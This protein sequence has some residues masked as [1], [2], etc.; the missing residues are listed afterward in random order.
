MWMLMSD[1][2][3]EFW[4]EKIFEAIAQSVG[5]FIFFDEQLLRWGNKQLA[6]VLVEFEL[7][8]GL[9]DVIDLHIKDTHLR[10]PVDFWKEPFRCHSCWQPGHIKTNFPDLMEHNIDPAQLEVTED[11]AGTFGLEVF[12][13]ISFLGKMQLFFP[14]FFNKLS[15]DEIDYLKINESWVL[16]IFGDFW[17]LLM[18]KFEEPGVRSGLGTKG[19]GPVNS[20]GCS[21]RDT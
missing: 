7:D 21:P 16:E 5:K 18:K 6:W 13:K 3:I 11:Q 17:D 20:L 19:V 14:S 15:S 8:R 12:D 4:L 1:F 10:Q 9:P 2:P